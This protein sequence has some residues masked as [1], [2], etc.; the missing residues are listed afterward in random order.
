MSCSFLLYSKV[1]RLSIYTYSFFCGF[2][3]L[4]RSPQSI[5]LSSLHCIPVVY[6]R[7]SLASS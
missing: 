1:I 3:S 5:E 6:S 7:F 4:S 2:P